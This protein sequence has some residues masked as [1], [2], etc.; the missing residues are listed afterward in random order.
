[1]NELIQKGFFREANLVYLVLKHFSNLK[2]DEKN[3]YI[4]KGISVS[5]LKKYPFYTDNSGELRNKGLDGWT[6]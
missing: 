2:I 3:I 1:M 5:G 6:N 4:P